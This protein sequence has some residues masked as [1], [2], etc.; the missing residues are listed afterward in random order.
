MNTRPISKHLIM[1]VPNLITLEEHFVSKNIASASDC[2]SG[3]HV[4]ILSKLQ[5]LG[6]ERLRDMD[7]GGVSFKSYL[8]HL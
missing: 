2:Y 1:P 5:S 4:P 3:W 7:N 8:M 6:D